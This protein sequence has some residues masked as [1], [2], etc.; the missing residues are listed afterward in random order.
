MSDGTGDIGLCDACGHAFT[1]N[2]EFHSSQSTM[3][4][5][6]SNHIASDSEAS[7]I[8]ASVMHAERQL[9]SLDREIGRLY[10]LVDLLKTKRRDTL[11]YI[12]QQSGILSPVRAL[13]AEIL[14]EIFAFLC[15]EIEIVPRDSRNP[16]AL[17]PLRVSQVCSQWREAALSTPKLWSNIAIHAMQK[18]PIPSSRVHLLRLH[19][20][21]SQQCPL[22]L[23]LNIG[24]GSVDEARPLVEQL[25]EHSHRWHSVN[26]DVAPGVIPFLD[27]AKCRLPR[28]EALTC[29]L[30]NSHGMRNNNWKVVTLDAFEFAP[31][32]R[33]V[34]LGLGPLDREPPPLPWGQITHL[35]SHSAELALEIIKLSESLETCSVFDLGWNHQHNSLP[36]ATS[37]RLRSL[38]LRV[39]DELMLNDLLGSLTLP[40]LTTVELSSVK[41]QRGS[42]G[43]WPEHQFLSLLLRSGCSLGTLVL[44][45]LRITTEMLLRCLQ[46]VPTL[47]TLVFQ[48]LVTPS[49]PAVVTDEVL[50]RL[51]YDSSA[52]HLPLVPHLVRV[53]FTGQ[54]PVNC[55]TLITMLKSRLESPQSVHLTRHAVARLE[56]VSLNFW[57]P[58]VDMVAIRELG[59]LLDA[60]L[61]LS[62][63]HCEKI[64]V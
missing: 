17:S 44:K 11:A 39:T 30:Q 55:S 51:T 47:H 29:W 45:R 12:S 62:I 21:R 35:V 9:S 52:C 40:A 18:Y 50:T 27:G 53:N 46:E 58:E 22:T 32:L 26:L 43:E 49:C 4:V 1:P 33:F 3:N 42:G 8:R 64:V 63:R 38:S 34:H 24:R 41:N 56:S 25:V 31:Q 54:L 7:H 61:K 15:Q 5:L 20:E 59:T 23:R 6:R 36:Y 60:S 48:E 28:L 19:L 2:P 16:A 14:A 13:P 57:D 10:T 37:Y